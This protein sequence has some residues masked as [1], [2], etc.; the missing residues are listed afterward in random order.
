MIVCYYYRKPRADYFS[1]EGVFT[2]VCEALPSEV[3]AKEWFCRFHRGLAG[4]MYN[5]RIIGRQAARGKWFCFP[6]CYLDYAQLEHTPLCIYDVG[7]VPE[8]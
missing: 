3:Q 5:V 2:T 6:F 4:R 1:T 7:T 8:L